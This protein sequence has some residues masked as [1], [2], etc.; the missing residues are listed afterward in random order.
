VPLSATVASAG[1]YAGSEDEEDF[2]K[3]VRA[4]EEFRA[5]NL[6]ARGP[7]S[8]IVG[9]RDQQSESQFANTADDDGQELLLPLTH[10]RATSKEHAG[11]LRRMKDERQRKKEQAARELEERRKSLA[12]RARTPSIQ[13]P[14]QFPRIGIETS[15]LTPAD[16]LPPRSATEPPKSMFA[17]DGPHIGL[18]ATPKAMRLILEDNNGNG[19]N[20]PDVPPI[21]ATFAQRHSPQTSPDASPEKEEAPLTLLPSTVYQPPPRPA[22]PRS[23]SAPIPAEPGQSYGRKGSTGGIDQVMGGSSQVR[24]PEDVPPMPPPP[25]MLKELQHLA[26][27]PPPPPA[28]LPH[29]KRSHAS[30]SSAID[31]GMIEIV[32]DE[33]DAPVAAPNDGMVP[34][35][36][37][38]APP[39]SKGGHGHS[40]G[41]S[42]GGESSSTSLSDRISKATE[43]LRSAS[44]GR[45]ESARGVKSPPVEA[46]YESVPMPVHHGHHQQHM[47]APSMPAVHYD[48]DSLRSPVEGPKTTGLHK[49]ELI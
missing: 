40:R 38:P 26:T 6:A 2:K 9:R 39:A 22:I 7:N 33:D 19:Q 34:V 24:S 18:P 11:D 15:D 13:Q 23:M 46:P 31:Q 3:A 43:R 32:M 45:K 29:V 25:P 41:R 1:F 10:S 27:P 42:I 28:P 47:K 30:S 17:R 48:P 36:P 35:I 16:D 44:R 14:K 37:P 21:P 8:P 5:R 49:S 12:Q 4:Q 20:A